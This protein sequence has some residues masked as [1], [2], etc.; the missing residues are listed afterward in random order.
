MAL[1]NRRAFQ[2]RLRCQAPYRADLK[3]AEINMGMQIQAGA[4]GTERPN[5]SEVA[6]SE[7]ARTSVADSRLMA[8]DT[9]P[10]TG[11]KPASV[12][13]ELSLA[14]YRDYRRYRAAGAR[15]ALSVIA[16]TQ[17]FW[18]SAVFRLSHWAL[19]RFTLPGLRAVINAVCLLFQ[20]FIEVLTGISLP[21]RS[22]I[23]AGLYIGHFGGIFIDV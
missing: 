15:N 17:G 20:K 7:R 18:A 6:R 5:A 1:T 8:P 21:A 22:N 23:G 3:N 13:Y 10:N 4:W 12:S 11:S 16:L 9:V 2:L 14:I 19:N